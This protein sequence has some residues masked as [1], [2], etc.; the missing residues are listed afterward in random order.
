MSGPNTDDTPPV[1]GAADNVHMVRDRL[2]GIPDFPFPAGFGLR[3]IRPGEAGVWAEVWNDADEGRHPVD[4]Q[5]FAGVFGTDWSVI[6]ERCFFVTGPGGGAVGTISAWFDERF[7]AKV[8]GRVH[9]VATRKAYQGRGLCRAALAATLG[10]L[11]RWHPKAYLTTQATRCR[12]ITVYARFGFRP[13]IRNAD[14]RRLWS[15]VAAADPGL[16]ALLGL[17]RL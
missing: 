13:V 7:S 11:A 14:D 3:P 16:G 4:E 6:G 9:W 5:T 2:D 15:E 1:T 17:E 10:T 8:D 12:A